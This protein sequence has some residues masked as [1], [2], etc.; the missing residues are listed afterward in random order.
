MSNT[1]AQ[2]N[3]TDSLS[4][5]LAKNINP[6]FNI[7]SFVMSAINL[8]INEHLDYVY[9]SSSLKEAQKI[10]FAKATFNTFQAQIHLDVAREYASKAA[11]Y[12]PDLGSAQTVL[13]NSNIQSQM[14]YENIARHYQNIAQE[15]TNKALSLGPLP[16]NLGKAMLVHAGNAFSALSMAEAISKDNAGEISKT[17]LSILSGMAA[18]AIA[19]TAITAFG[20]SAIAAGGWALAAGTLAGIITG[21]AWDY[22]NATELLGLDAQVPAFDPFFEMIHSLTGW[23]GDLIDLLPDDLAKLI[24]DWTGLNRLGRHYFIVDPLVLDLDGDG[25]EILAH[26]GNRG[27][28]FDFDADGLANATGWVKS[29]DGILVLDRNG[30]GTITD[31]RE[32]FGDSTVLADGSLA[33]HGFVALADLDSNG[34]GKITSLDSRFAE[35]RVWRDLDQD[36]VS[37]AGELFTLGELGIAELN[38]AYTDTNRHLVGGNQLAQL[39]NYT[40]ADGSTAVMGDV[41]FRFSNVHTKHLS[42]INTDDLISS[43]NLAGAGR[44]RNLSESMALSKGLHTLVEAFAKAKSR[45]EQQQMMFNLLKS[46]AM[47]DPE[48]KEYVDNMEQSIVSADQKNAV[49]VVRDGSVTSPLFIGFDKEVQDAFDA[50]KT[51]IGIIDSFMG[52]HTD[53]LYYVTKNDVVRTTKIINDIYDQIANSVYHG[54]YPQ[55][56]NGRYEAMIDVAVT[57]DDGMP[58]FTLKLD[59]LIASFA[60]K[61]ATG[62]DSAGWAFVD[63]VEYSNYLHSKGLASHS[64]LLKLGKLIHGFITESNPETLAKWTAQLDKSKLNNISFGNEK[65]EQLKGGIVFGLEGNDTINATERSDVLHGGDGNDYITANKGD[66]YLDGG[67][68]DD[69]LYGGEGDDVLIGGAGND[70]LDGGYGA[71]TYVFSGDY[72]HDVIQEANSHN[73]TAID[74]LRFTDVKFD[75]VQVALT[76]NNLVLRTS[77]NNSVTMQS[78]QNSSYYHIERFEFAD[79]TVSLEE[80]MTAKTASIEGTERTESIVTTLWKGDVTANLGAGNDQITIGRETTATVYGDAG[81][82]TI[83]SGDLNDK[84]HGGD[85]NDYITA[86][87]GDDYLDG[88]AGDDSLYGGEGDDVLIGG[89]GNDRLDGGYGADTYVFN[90][91]AGFESDATFGNGFD[92]IGRFSLAQGDKIDLSGLFD[93]GATIDTLLNYVQFEH[94][95]NNTIC[96]SIDRD[97]T[98]DNYSQTQ[99]A[100]LYVDNIEHTL[101]QLNQGIGIII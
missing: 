52:T 1:N 78:F 73:S 94:T 72:G 18:A 100:E 82:D 66:D 63:A 37:D 44:V 43:I 8:K 92:K 51:K 17:G 47:T 95:A 93:N 85:G 81:N 68:G 23:D 77:A 10:Q 28:M 55:V 70:R 59:R 89:A 32:L 101:K 21:M 33:K 42:A 84:L 40:K 71:D 74:T 5:L 65:S 54:L 64:E 88:G 69:S 6:K 22:F 35:L 46:W 34:D 16:K 90:Q 15:Y 38:T 56:V 53:K 4:A 9:G 11:K 41:N 39:G 2:Q 98:Q 25:I 79:K 48:Y 13:H 50:A 19:S 7:P 29:D 99:L 36:G 49:G 97:G 20:Y 24:N 12:S 75:D 31:G 14:A 3:N 62:G 45:L 57:F 58:T 87:K 80:L 83:H 27:A 91:I 30:D 86:N 67:A 76:N 96:M 60:D 26:Q 61:F